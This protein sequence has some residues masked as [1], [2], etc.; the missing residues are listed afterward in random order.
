[1]VSHGSAARLIPRRAFEGEKRERESRQIL[2]HKRVPCL[3]RPFP[4]INDERFDRSGYACYTHA[5]PGCRDPRA[6]AVSLGDANRSIRNPLKRGATAHLKKK[7]SRERLVSVRLGEQILERVEKF[8]TNLM[9]ASPGLRVSLS[10]AI[11]ILV[12]EGLDKQEGGLRIARRK[13]AGSQRAT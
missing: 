11:R 1:M 7:N 2:M 3:T 9:A 10:E 4:T 12:L 8:R 6:R 13:G 5:S